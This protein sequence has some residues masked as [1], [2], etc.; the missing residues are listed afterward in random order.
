MN[1]EAP[2]V[3]IHARRVE[4]AARALASLSPGEPWPSNAMLGG[5]LTG[6]RDD[7]YRDAMYEQAREVIAA[8]DAVP[9]A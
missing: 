9:N 3:A 5:G 7:E 6:T 4:A 2:R 1:N 8:I